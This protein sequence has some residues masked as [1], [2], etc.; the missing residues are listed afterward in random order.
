MKVLCLGNNT[1]DTDTITRN[2]AQIALSECHGLLSELDGPIAPCRRWL[3]VNA[4]CN[5]IKVFKK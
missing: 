4:L 2:L 5:R 1:Q 3:L